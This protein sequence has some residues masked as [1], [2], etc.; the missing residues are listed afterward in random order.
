MLKIKISHLK[1]KLGPNPSPRAIC[2]KHEAE[3]STTITRTSSLHTL[4]Y[5]MHPGE[6]HAKADLEINKTQKERP[7]I[8]VRHVCAVDVSIHTVCPITVS[9]CQRIPEQGMSGKST[10]PSENAQR[11]QRG[12]GGAPQKLTAT[13][14]QPH[15]GGR[16]TGQHRDPIERLDAPR[17]QQPDAQQI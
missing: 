9:I 17:M 11:R 3:G 6:S 4:H 16:L 15:L 5:T 1:K 12:G 7:Q 10:G 13:E 2:T 14:T 8:E